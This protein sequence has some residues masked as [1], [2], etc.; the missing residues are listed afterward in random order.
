MYRKPN[1]EPNLKIGHEIQRSDKSHTS[2][3]KPNQRINLHNKDNV[4]YLSKGN[5]SAYSSVSDVLIINYFA[6]HI[7]GLETINNV[8]MINYLRCITDV[9]LHIIKK[10]DM[11]SILDDNNLWRCAFDILS[12]GVRILHERDNV[13]TKKTSKDTIIHYIKYIWSLPH[14]QRE[15]I[16]IYP[17]IMERTHISR[18][19]I[20]RVATELHSKN[21]IIIQ[22]GVLKNC[23]LP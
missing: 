20:H 4:I 5:A 18:S 19:L 12:G 13:N 14:T 2:I 23:V 17:F 21:L 16:S 6:P 10:K 7:V 15:T 3:Y 8:N 22:R 11:I 9:T 1:N